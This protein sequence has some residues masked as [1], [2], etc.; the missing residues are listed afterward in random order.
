MTCHASFALDISTCDQRRVRIY[1]GV[2]APLWF[3]RRQGYKGLSVEIFIR[4]EVKANLFAYVSLCG[5]ERLSRC[6]SVV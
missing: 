6:A 2:Y 3:T 1:C 5:M 4:V